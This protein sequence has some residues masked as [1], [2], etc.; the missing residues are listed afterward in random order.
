MKSVICFI[1]VG[2]SN[3]HGSISLAL[4]ICNK[5]SFFS[6]LAKSRG[7]PRSRYAQN[8]RETIMPTPV[9]IWLQAILQY[10]SETLY[11]L[12]SL[13]LTFLYLYESD[14]SRSEWKF[15]VNDKYGILETPKALDA[16][17]GSIVGY[18]RYG[19]TYTCCSALLVISDEFPYSL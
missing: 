4:N 11:V 7:Y 8:L 5:C 14:K 18:G 13:S 9:Q 12:T 1:I 15:G 19:V 3:V 6:H 16:N 10:T 2:T 17:F